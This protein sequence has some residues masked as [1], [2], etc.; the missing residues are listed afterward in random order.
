[1]GT[2]TATTII[3]R[4]AFLLEDTSNT[5]WTRAELLSWVNEGQS[6]VVAFKPT[7]NI[8]RQNLSL[9]AGTQQTLPADSTLLIDIP[10]N[11]EGPAIRLVSRELLDAGP[12]DWHTARTSAV[13]KNFV[14]DADD[15]GSFYVFPPNN[16]AGNVVVRYAK[17]PAVLT[18]EAQAIEL[19]DGYQAALL[20]YVMYRAYSKDTDYVADAT[21]AAGFYNAFKEALGGKSAGDAEANVNSA[22]GPADPSNQGSLK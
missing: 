7:A 3:N 22:L 8:V 2:V 14:Y 11:V 18:N 4:A 21:K 10:R 15:S 9:V 6:Q 16:G 13:V 1:M 19:E 17:L 20:N 5:T 12:Y